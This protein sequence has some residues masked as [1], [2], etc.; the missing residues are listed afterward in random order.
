MWIYFVLAVFGVFDF[1]MASNN[2]DFG[3]TLALILGLTI[4]IIVFFACM[5]AYARRRSHFESL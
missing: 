2:F 3:D 5:G 4:G 1:A